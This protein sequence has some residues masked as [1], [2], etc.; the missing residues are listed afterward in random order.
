MVGELSAL[1]IFVFGGDFRAGP[2]TVLPASLGARLVRDDARGGYRVDH[3]FR[4]DPDAPGGLAPLSRYGV[5]VSDGDVIEAVNG[6]RTLSV[7]DIGALLRGQSDRQVLLRVKPKN[8]SPREVIVSP[9]TQDAE[10]NL[11]YAAWEYTPRLEVAVQSKGDI[12]Y[13]HLF[14]V[15]GRDFV[16][17]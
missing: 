6:V 10:R 11:L 8:G 4:G 14:S 3:V 15:A 13:V 1:H 5:D 17:I 9:T 2:D 16:P 12:R 7:S